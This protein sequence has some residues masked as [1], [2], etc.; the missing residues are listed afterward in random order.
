MKGAEEDLYE[1]Y[2]EEIEPLVQIGNGVKSA[3]VNKKIEELKEE[4]YA[5]KNL[6]EEEMNNLRTE[7]FSMIQELGY[8]NELTDKV[9]KG[10]ITSDEAKA[11]YHGFSESIPK[12][13]K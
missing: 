10:E 5:M 6:Y 7:M 3:K 12:K 2:S 8:K 1:F 4:L 11:E 9:K 13:S